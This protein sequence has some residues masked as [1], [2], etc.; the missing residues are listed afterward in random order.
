MQGSFFVYRK[1]LACLLGILDEGEI[2]RNDFFFIHGEI[3]I[4][5]KMML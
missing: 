5:D 1:R 4:D 2:D 3:G